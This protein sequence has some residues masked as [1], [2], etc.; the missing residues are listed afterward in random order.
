M[1]DLRQAVWSAADAF[2]QR[3]RG[4]LEGHEPDQE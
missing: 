1:S 4:L 3:L 2:E